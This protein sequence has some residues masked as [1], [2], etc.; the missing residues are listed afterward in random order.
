MDH[1]MKLDEMVM[2]MSAIGYPLTDDEILVILLGS[3]TDIFLPIIR[4]IENVAS[5]DLLCAK[6]ILQREWEDI[7]QI[8]SE[9]MALNASK[10]K[11]NY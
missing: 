4:I 11:V 8:D 10:M 2:N 5:I 7:R 9:E 1:L 6:E 3:L